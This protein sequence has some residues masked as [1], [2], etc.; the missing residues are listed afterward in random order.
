MSAEIKGV[1]VD[2]EVHWP[3]TNGYVPRDDMADRALLNTFSVHADC[4]TGDYFMDA[5]FA[6]RVTCTVVIL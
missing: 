2:G 6:S 5:R 3:G 4:F 1:V